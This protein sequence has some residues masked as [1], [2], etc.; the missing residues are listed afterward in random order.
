MTVRR[1]LKSCAIPPASVPTDSI[2]WAC[3]N[4][5]SSFRR[6]V[7]SR[8]AAEPNAPSAVSSRLKLTST[9]N[10]TPSVEL[11]TR[12][13]ESSLR[14]AEKCSPQLRT[15]LP[16]PLGHQ[17]FHRLP[18]HLITPVSER[19]L[20]LRIHEDNPAFSIHRHHGNGG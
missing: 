8:M 3:R 6:S 11:Q 5:L 16:Q 18:E 19:F 12:S 20:G 9:G 2:F 1:L 14:I 4:W 10:P 7:K 17:G 13:H 15:F